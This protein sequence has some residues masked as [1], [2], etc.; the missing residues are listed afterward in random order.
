LIYETWRKPDLETTIAI[1]IWIDKYEPVGQQTEVQNK[2]WG[3]KNP[4]R[5]DG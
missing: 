2:D 3:Q 5:G 1:R 4:V